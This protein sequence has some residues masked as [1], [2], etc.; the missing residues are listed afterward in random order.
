MCEEESRKDGPWGKYPY[1]L[2]FLTVFWLI[3]CFL[4]WPLYSNPDCLEPLLPRTWYR[5]WEE[6]AVI[7]LRVILNFCGLI[8]GV[9]ALAFGVAAP[10]SP[11]VKGVDKLKVAALCLFLALLWLA[12][13]LRPTYGTAFERGKRIGCEYHIR[14]IYRALTQYAADNGGFLPPDLKTLESPKYLPDE[15][16]THCPGRW[17]ADDALPDYLYFGK[18][19]KLNEPAFLLLCDR[20]GNHPGTFRANIS[21]DGQFRPQ[22]DEEGK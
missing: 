20:P 7:R 12:V 17:G 5:E 2:I 14:D 15:E 8:V 18:D 16:S 6:F 13:P 19:R 4:L 1:L 9:I 3:Y 11:H 10:F 22:M 21:S